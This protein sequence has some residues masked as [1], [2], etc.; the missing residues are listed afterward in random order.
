MGRLYVVATPIGNL[1]DISARALRILGEADLIAAEDTRHSR[2]LLEHYGVR[3]PLTSFHEHNE[4]EKTPELIE[5]MN[6]GAAVALIADAGTPCISDPGYLLVRAA[7]EAGIEVV[8]VPGPSALAAA[9]SISGLPAEPLTFHGFFPRKAGKARDLLKRCRDFGGAHVFFEAPGRVRAALGAI[10][11]NAPGATVAVARE[12]TKHY[13][14]I[15]TGSIETLADEANAFPEKGEFVLVVYPGSSAGAAA[16]PDPS[17]LRSCVETLMNE[18]GLSR[19]D[20]IRQVA[21]D[22]N[23]PRNT[24]Y[25]AAMETD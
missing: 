21:K 4:R 7:H 3:T 19:R 20:A 12:M 11:E 5:R 6:Q 9:A 10:R 18:Q 24:V 8:A 22:R 2:R 25:A 13:E 17:E 14:Q 16:A 1:E 23:V 15:V